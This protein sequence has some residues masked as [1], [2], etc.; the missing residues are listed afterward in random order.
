MQQGMY[1]DRLGELFQL[2]AGR[3]V[4][5]DQ[6][7]TGLQEG[8]V[9]GELGNRVPAVAEDARLSVDVGDLR[10]AAGGVGQARIQGDHPGVGQQGVQVSRL[11][12]EAPRVALVIDI[13]CSPL[14]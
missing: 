1:T 11:I 13:G 14:E 10:R 7:V 9:L 4:P 8:R 2:T 3:Q 5:I 12:P 6:Q